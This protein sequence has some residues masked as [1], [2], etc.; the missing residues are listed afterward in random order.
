MRPDASARIKAAAPQQGPSKTVIGAIVAAVVIIGVVVAVIIGSNG[1]GGGGA[2]VTGSGN[3]VPV[4]ATGPGGGIVANPGK[5]RAGAP[6]LE[7]YEDFQCP[8]CG[9]FERAMGSQVTRLAQAGDVRL[10]IHMM[11]FLD[12]N[13]HNDSSVRAAAASACAAD[14]GRFLPFHAAVYAGQP[15]TEGEGYTDA[16]LRSF[17]QQAG[18]TG[19]ALARWSACYAG[20]KHVKY[21]QAVETAA[22]KAGVFQTPTIKVNGKELALKD[23]TPA[24]LADQVKAATK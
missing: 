11:S 17:A 20:G 21:A 1:G 2:V 22:E 12:A 9:A 15:T 13:L 7:L 14:Q 19:D 23:L 16:K 10:V 24:Y 3:A 18:I 4:G 5:S 6:T 8:V